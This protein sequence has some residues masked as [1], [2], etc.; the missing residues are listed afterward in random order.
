MPTFQSRSATVLLVVLALLAMLGQHCVVPLGVEVAAGG[1]H[2]HP[3]RDAAHGHGTTDDG[4]A[5]HLSACH[6]VVMQTPT[7]TP[8]VA[9]VA[10]AGLAEVLHAQAPRDLPPVPIEPER[11]PRYILHAA[12]LI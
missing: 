10:R 12:L 9:A 11:P 6:V 2:E 8:S 5:A 3:A 1:A 4:A 7:A